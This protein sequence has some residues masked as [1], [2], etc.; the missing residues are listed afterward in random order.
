L[1]LASGPA[2]L[3]LANGCLLMLIALAAASSGAIFLLIAGFDAMNSLGSSVVFGLTGLMLIG[4]AAGCI[5]WL[6][7]LQ[8]K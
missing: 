8:H 3:H 1:K 6:I 7:Q 5:Y 2:W 4:L